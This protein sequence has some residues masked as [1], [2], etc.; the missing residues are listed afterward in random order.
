[1]GQGY[2]S[3]SALLLPNPNSRTYVTTSKHL[4]EEGLGISRRQR[5][6]REEEEELKNLLSSTPASDLLGGA[7]RYDSDLASTSKDSF[8]DPM[9]RRTIER[10]KSARAVGLQGEELEAYRR[11]WTK[12]NPSIAATASSS[13]S[14]RPVRC[15]VLDDEK[16]T[17]VSH[18]ASDELAATLL[19][20]VKGLPEDSVAEL[21]QRARELVIREQWK[22]CDYMIELPAEAIHTVG[23]CLGFRSLNAMALTCRR[24]RRVLASVWKETGLLLFDGFAVDG[25]VFD[26]PTVYTGTSRTS[27]EYA[28]DRQAEDH[29]FWPLRCGQ[30]MKAIAFEESPYL[31]LRN[32]VPSSVQL[33]ATEAIDVT[34][35]DIGDVLGDASPSQHADRLSRADSHSPGDDEGEGRMRAMALGSCS[36][37]CPSKFEVPTT[38][39][40]GIYLEYLV[41]LHF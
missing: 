19:G 8:R 14:S 32:G 27:L 36:F 11:K 28:V 9:V 15:S 13:G 17:D 24:L 12:G 20:V 5:G 25:E 33:R 21:L 3:E 1:Y 4:A 26:D 7:C 40:R 35:E 39:E 23:L 31:V 34:A 29:R 38:H 10:S 16:D 6:L 30:F 37:T 22:G 2:F 18:A 41:D